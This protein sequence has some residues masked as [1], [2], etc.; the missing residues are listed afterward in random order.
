M[1]FSFSEIG[2]VLVGVGM[3]E[4]RQVILLDPVH[5][6][7]LSVGTHCQRR[8]LAVASN[9]L[10]VL[11]KHKSSEGMGGTEALLIGC[12]R[13]AAVANHPVI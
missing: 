8:Q 2:E 12:R 4:K 11:Y 5:L 13:L 6:N 9:Q 10:N 7:P 3:Y 1:R